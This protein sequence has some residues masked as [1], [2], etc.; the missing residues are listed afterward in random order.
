MSA[1][2]PRPCFLETSLLLPA[3]SLGPLWVIYLEEWEKSFVEKDV[4]PA[5]FI[6]ILKSQS[7]MFTSSPLD[8][9]VKCSVVIL[10]NVFGDAGKYMYC[11][12]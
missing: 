10:N 1:Q 2:V 8:C 5:F 3:H 12:C 4:Q 7:Q 9:A 6:R 11:I